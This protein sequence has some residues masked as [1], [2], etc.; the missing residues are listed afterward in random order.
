VRHGQ[1]RGVV[2]VLLKL[3]L[4]GTGVD[5]ALAPTGTQMDVTKSSY[6]PGVQAAIGASIA[7]S[8]AGEDSDRGRDGDQGG[9][10]AYDDDP[11]KREADTR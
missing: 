10:A 3:L 5:E 1:P 8:G 9:K 7:G 4:A 2:Y 6:A 11:T